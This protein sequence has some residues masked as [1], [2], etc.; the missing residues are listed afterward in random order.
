M[1]VEPGE[2]SAQERWQPAVTTD[3]LLRKHGALGKPLSRID[4]PL[5]VQGKVR[6]AAEFP[7]ENICYAALVFSRIARGRITKLDTGRADSA[8]GVVLVM[9]YQNA[10]RMKAPSLMMSS[11]T[12]AGAS[13]LPVMQNDEV[14]WNGQ[15]VALVLG[16]TQEQADFAASLIRVE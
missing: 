4:G 3:P 13:D 15:P 16:E 9:T 11:P 6:F 10:P 12:A 5:K 2:N 8:P 7:Y 14:H 1:S